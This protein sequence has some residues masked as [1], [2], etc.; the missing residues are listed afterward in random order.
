MKSAILVP[1]NGHYRK[2]LGKLESKKAMNLKC[3]ACGS[4]TGSPNACR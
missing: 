4:C 3:G 1:K 2:V